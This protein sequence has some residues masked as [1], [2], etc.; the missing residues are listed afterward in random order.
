MAVVPVRIPRIVLHVPD[1]HIVPVYYIQAS[2]RSK[3]KVDRPEIRVAAL[4]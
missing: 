4:Q 1:Q 2:V 3:F